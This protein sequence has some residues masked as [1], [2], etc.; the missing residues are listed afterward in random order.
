[1]KHAPGPIPS[2]CVTCRRRNAMEAIPPAQGVLLEDTNAS[3][4]DRIA[5]SSGLVQSHHSWTLL[6]LYTCRYRNPGFALPQMSYAV[7]Y[8]GFKKTTEEVTFL[9]SYNRFINLSLFKS[10]AN[11]STSVSTSRFD[12]SLYSGCPPPSHISPPSRGDIQNS[13]APAAQHRS[14]EVL[15]LAS[16]IPLEALG[17][18]SSALPPPR[19]SLSQDLIVLSPIFSRERQGPPNGSLSSP[20]TLPPRFYPNPVI[21]GTTTKVILSLYEP[22]FDPLAFNLIYIRSNFIRD[23]L[24]ARV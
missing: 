16:S 15:P 12:L 18:P 8:L 14:D 21:S 11:E 9:H 24:V 3:G 5:S 19:S 22:L 6:L 13:H 17:L 1:M 23:T 7:H 10:I 4:Y 20:F 2:S